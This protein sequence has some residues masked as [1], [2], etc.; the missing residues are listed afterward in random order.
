[1]HK[2]YELD[3][4]RRKALKGESSGLRSVHKDRSQDIEG[5]KKVRIF[6]PALF[7]MT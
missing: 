4:Q 5:F 7:F 3:Q 6:S 2:E 1:M